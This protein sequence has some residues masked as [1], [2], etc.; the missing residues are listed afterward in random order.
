MGMGYQTKKSEKAK[1]V[2]SW[3]RLTMDFFPRT[4]IKFQRRIES[5]LTDQF[6]LKVIKV[7]AKFHQSNK[8]VWPIKVSS[9]KY[10]KRWTSTA[11]YSASTVFTVYTAFTP[12]R[13]CYKKLIYFQ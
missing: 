7:N 3:L 11:L 13:D 12:S 10:C 8:T 2:T 4:R 1:L 5:I 6:G 9:K